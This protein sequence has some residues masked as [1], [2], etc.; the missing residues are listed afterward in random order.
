V[1]HEFGKFC[2]FGVFGKCRIDRFMHIKYVFSAKNDKPYHVYF[3]LRDSTDSLT[4]AKPFTQDLPD[5]PTFA[6]SFTEDSP[7][8]Q[9]FAKPFTKY[10]PYSPSFA[11][12]YF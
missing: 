4:F 2:E 9:T 8:W 12:G 5:S 1:L 10:S 6:K 11:K 3:D 7:D